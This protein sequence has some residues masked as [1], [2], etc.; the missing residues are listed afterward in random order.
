VIPGVTVIGAGNF[1]SANFATTS[2]GIYR[3]IAHYSGDANNNAVDA[4]CNDAGETS[5][6]NL[7]MSILPP[8]GTTTSGVLPGTGYAPQRVTALSIQPAEKTYSDL[9]DLWLEIPSLGVQMP[10]VGVP[11]SANGW[12]VTW[13]SNQT[14]WLQG[15]AFP[16]CAGNSVLTGHV[17]DANGNLGPFGHLNWLFYGDRIIIHFGGQQYIYE[18]R[19]ISTVAPSAVSS[20]IRHENLP[21]IT[22]VTC[23]GYDE[24][25]NSYKYRI[26]VRAV[27][28]EVE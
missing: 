1:S 21:W 11:L 26:V 20:V 12:D 6:V 9:G 19:S 8:T 28:V 27:Q 15:T 3:W 7:T 23:K 4:V 16:T 5:M 14:G 24:K 22:L 18:V 13:L 10:I 25:S 17:H 2:V